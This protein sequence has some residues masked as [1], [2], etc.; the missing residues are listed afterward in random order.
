MNLPWQANTTPRSKKSRRLYN[1]VANMHNCSL[2][3]QTCN[4]LTW[5]TTTNRNKTTLS[6]PPTTTT[7]RRTP[8]ESQT[9][10]RRNLQILQHTGP[11]V[12]RMPQTPQ[13]RSQRNNEE[14]T[15]MSSTWKQQCTTTRS[16]KTK[17]QLQ[18]SMPNLWQDRTFHTGLQIQGTRCIDLP[19]CTK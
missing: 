16:Q 10:I 6:R 11:Q 18:T 12:D 13:G 19:K 17:L 8:Q 14:I 4:H 5:S 9:K 1:A 7:P 3:P 15:T 2:A